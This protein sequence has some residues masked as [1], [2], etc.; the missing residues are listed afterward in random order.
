MV[1][2][3]MPFYKYEVNEYYNAKKGKHTM[4]I[5]VHLRIDPD[6]LAIATSLC[7]Q[8]MRSSQ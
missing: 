7:D 4:K 1:I 5:G 6:R 2:L 8:V 3:I